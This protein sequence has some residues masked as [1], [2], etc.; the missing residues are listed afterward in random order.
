MPKVLANGI[1]IH[2]Q[3]AGEGPDVVLVHGITGDLSNWY[4]N[5]MPALAKEFRVTAYDLRGH[6]DSDVTPSGYTS[7]HM[8][9]DLHGLL[10]G[11][12]IERAHLVGTSFGAT[13]A[14]HCAVLY[15]E[16]VTSLVLA[17]PWISALGSRAIPGN[18][19]YSEAA[20][21]ALA[22]RGLSIPEDKWD[23]WE[24]IT[25][26]GLRTPIRT[27][28]R[29]GMA[30]NS[31]RIQR[32]LDS[33]SAMKEAQEVAGLMMERIAEI[34]QPTLAV[35]GETSPFLQ[36]AWQLQEKMPPC[37]VVVLK[38]VGHMF[39]LLKPELFVATFTEFLRQP[40]GSGTSNGVGT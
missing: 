13:V 18:W 22:E 12:G 32:L 28:L 21:A 40:D 33:T 8:A 6:G 10:A 24:Y 4:L 19:S 16:R 23:D 31:R 26:T 9:A 5:V 7:A 34:R 25:R 20:K 14:L 17:E 30:R 36:T 2:Y 27:G 15:P 29:R 11:L 1:H 3:Q 38:D 35:Y 37:R 39:P